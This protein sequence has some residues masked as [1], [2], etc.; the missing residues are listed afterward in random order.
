MDG[1]HI[2]GIS[3]DSPIY[4]EMKGK[5]NGDQFSV[6]GNQYTIKEIL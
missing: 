5:K 1:M 6:S 4:K 3:T 2:V